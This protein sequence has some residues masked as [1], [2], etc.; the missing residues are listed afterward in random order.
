MS[1]NVDILYLEYFFSFHLPVH[2]HALT[3]WSVFC[4]RIKDFLIKK[5]R[6]EKKDIEMLKKKHFINQKY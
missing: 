6:T 3:I 2:L 5:E 1:N 4:W